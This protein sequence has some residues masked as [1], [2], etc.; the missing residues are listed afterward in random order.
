MNAEIDKD[1]A[2]KALDYI[3]AHSI[4]DELM[5]LNNFLKMAYQESKKSAE[6]E[7]ISASG[8]I[9]QLEAELAV[10]KCRRQLMEQEIADLKDIIKD[11]QLELQLDKNGKFIG[12]SNMNLKMLF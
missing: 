9:L 1:E 4:A 3:A 8:R 11:L 10:E 6:T 7:S 2:D 12:W 5:K